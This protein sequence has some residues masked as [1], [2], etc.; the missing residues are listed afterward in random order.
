MSIRSL[1]KLVV[2]SS[3]RAALTA[4]LFGAALL[5]AAPAQALPAI[6]TG[7]NID[8]FGGVDPLGGADLSSATGVDFFTLGLASPGVA[9]TL[10]VSNTTGGAFL[11]F[12]TPLFNCPSLA[13]GGCGAIKDLLSFNVGT[14]TLI[15]PALPV[16]GFLSFAEV[17]SAASFDLATFQVTQLAPSGNQL[18]TIII[19][20]SGTMHFTG[21]ADTPAIMTLTGQGAGNTSFSGTVITQAPNTVPEPAS[22]ALLGVGLA[23][24]TLLRR[25]AR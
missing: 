16:S 24:M 13:L 3:P 15:N 5:A 11:V 23:G 9:G 17:G 22:M 19:A 12:T 1:K 20:G 2:E 14:Q 21:F 10:G 7:S 8:F 6:P 25:R 18:G 4:A